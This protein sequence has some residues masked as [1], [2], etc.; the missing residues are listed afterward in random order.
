MPIAT[1]EALIRNDGAQPNR[2]I[3][4]APAVGSFH[5]WVRP[6]DLVQPGDPIG[7]LTRL[8]TKTIVV[9][10]RPSPILKVASRPGPPGWSPVDYA[11]PLLVLEPVTP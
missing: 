3:V 6:G 2:T 11:T 8:N 1:V 10:A 7:E 9:L 4:A 5:P